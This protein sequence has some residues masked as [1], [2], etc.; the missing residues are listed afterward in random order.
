M[1]YLKLLLCLVMLGCS[2][3]SDA[4]VEITKMLVS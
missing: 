2:S 3:I 4:D 1:K